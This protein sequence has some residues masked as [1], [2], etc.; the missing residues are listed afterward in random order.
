MESKISYY[1][2]R[3]QGGTQIDVNIDARTPAELDALLLTLR[4]PVIAPP[5]GSGPG[6]G[7]EP[8][9]DPAP[10]TRQPYFD[11]GNAEGKAG[12]IVQIKMIGG[13]RHPVNGFHIGGGLA[14]YG[15][16][17]AQGA[18]LGPFLQAYLD[19]NNLS[20]HYWSIFQMVNWND[21]KALPEEWWEYAMS[22]FSISQRSAPLPPIQI[23]VDTI[24]FTLQI[25]ILDGTDPGTYPLTC[26]DE[27]YYTNT[28]QRRRDFLY[29][30]DKD[31]EFASGGVTKVDC[32]G[33][34]ITVLA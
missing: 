3:K 8:P 17:E 1:E 15:K 20:D 28:N 4:G 33:G 30:T 13:C 34:N 29:T 2:Y 24:L 23:P 11:L 31:S 10:T 26:K 32:T 12:D 19:A 14:E 27:F 6:G 5:P 16:F 7:V 22:T 25:K 18:L 21:N 9:P